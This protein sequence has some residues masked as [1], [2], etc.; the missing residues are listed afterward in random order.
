MEKKH[1]SRLLAEFG[2]AIDGKPIHVL[3]IPDEYKFVDPEL[4][5]LVRDSVAG[6]LGVE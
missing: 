1:R 3:D 5:E 2:Y 4:V 6:V